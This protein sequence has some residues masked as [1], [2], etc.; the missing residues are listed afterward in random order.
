MF[1]K[2]KEHRHEPTVLTYICK[3]S[4][5]IYQNSFYDK[6]APFLIVYVPILSGETINNS[7]RLSIVF[8]YPLDNCSSKEQMQEFYLSLILRSLL[9]ILTF[10]QCFSRKC[11]FWRMISI[12]NECGKCRKKIWTEF[13]YSYKNKC[14]FFKMVS[15]FSGECN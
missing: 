5:D 15:W 4:G 14:S 8:R 3:K 2:Y 7:R 12:D 6:E 11:C 13:K 10:D 9:S 1:L